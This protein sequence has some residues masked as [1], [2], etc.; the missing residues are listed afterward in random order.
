[1]FI[2]EIKVME[3]RNLGNYQHR[4]VT[5]SMALTKNDDGITALERINYQML[6]A[7]GYKGPDK[8][9]E[10][11]VEPTETVKELDTLPPEVPQKKVQKRKPAKKIGKKLEVSEKVKEEDVK[12]P[13]D[14]LPPETPLTLEAMIATCK[15]VATKLQSGDKVKSLIKQVCGVSSLGEADPAKFSELKTL[16]LN[17]V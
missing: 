1:M 5:L 2:N 8:T 16:L 10:E 17:A 15:E 9:C 7:L 11:E 6:I 14:T 3:R 12:L 4:E 13:L